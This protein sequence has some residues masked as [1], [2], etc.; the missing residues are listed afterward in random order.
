V[1][2]PWYRLKHQT[3]QR[4]LIEWVEIQ[5]AKNTAFSESIPTK[6]N[7]IACRLC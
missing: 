5:Q 3:A 2:I 7:I 6:V 1:E 4:R